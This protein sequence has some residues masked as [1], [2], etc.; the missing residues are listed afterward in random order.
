MPS[1]NSANVGVL[2]RAALMSR[3]LCTS[4]TGSGAGREHK[5]QKRT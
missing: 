3:A 5:R 1:P 4:R 2:H